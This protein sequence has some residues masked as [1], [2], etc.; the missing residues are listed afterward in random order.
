MNINKI[1]ERIKDHQLF[2]DVILMAFIYI[3]NEVKFM[4]TLMQKYS[5]KFN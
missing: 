4:M 3:L 2:Y 1:F 5:I